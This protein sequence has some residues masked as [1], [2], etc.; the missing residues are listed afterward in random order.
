MLVFL[1]YFQRC[2]MILNA[3]Q[4]SPMI[5]NDHVVISTHHFRMRRNNDHSTSWKLESS[6]LKSDNPDGLKHVD[7][8]PVISGKL[9]KEIPH[10]QKIDINRPTYHTLSS[11]WWT[12]TSSTQPLCKTP[13]VRPCSSCVQRRG[14]PPAVRRGISHE[15]NTTMNHGSSES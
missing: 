6:G 3:P 1:I 2:L 7:T 5:I 12:L 8:I 11:D 13:G 4:G 9:T 15:S 14:T 10:S